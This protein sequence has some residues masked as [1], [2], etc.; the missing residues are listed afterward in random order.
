[1]WSHKKGSPQQLRFP[2]RDDEVTTTILICDDRQDGCDHALQHLEKV[3]R[4]DGAVTLSKDSLRKALAALFE[5]ASELLRGCADSEKT[6]APEGLAG[7]DLVLFDNNLADLNFGGARL[8]AESVIGHLR[9]FTDS[10]YIISINKNPNVDFDLRHL[11]G[12]HGS[13]ADLALNTPHLSRPRLWGGQNEDFAPWYWPCLPDAAAK[14]K[15]QIAFVRRNLDKTV[16]KALGF[17]DEAV[18]CLYRKTYR[19]LPSAMCLVPTG[20]LIE[21]RPRALTLLPA[22]RF[23]GLSK[24]S[25]G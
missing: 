14:R 18:D 13:I 1:M 17:P 22:N 9:A 16:W 15:K 25:V 19:K 10:S 6:S 7:F 3:G 11:F 4:A 5:G 20:R 21:K 12:D 24:P 8:T 2:G 23:S